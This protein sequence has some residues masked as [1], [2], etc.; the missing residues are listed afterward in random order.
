MDVPNDVPIL[1]S[2]STDFGEEM[3]D[4]GRPVECVTLTCKKCGHETMSFGQ[5]DGSIR[6]CLWLMREECPEGRKAYYTDTSLID[7]K[8]FWVFKTKST[9]RT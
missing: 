4:F 1:V 9:G 3:G 6:R 8:D 2:C 7:G 5:H